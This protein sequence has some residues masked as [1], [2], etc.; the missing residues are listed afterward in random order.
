MEYILTEKPGEME[1]WQRT[2]SGVCFENL[3]LATNRT[4]SKRTITRVKKFEK[5]G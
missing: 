3:F 4:I 5:Y 2:F 1:K